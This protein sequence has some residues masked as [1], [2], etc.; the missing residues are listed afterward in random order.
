MTFDRSVMLLTEVYG[1]I[2][3][4]ERELMWDG[5]STKAIAKTLAFAR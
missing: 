3:P 2:H 4:F 1:Q 5:G